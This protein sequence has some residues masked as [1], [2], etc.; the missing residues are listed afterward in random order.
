MPLSRLDL[1]R[2]VEAIRELHRIIAVPP[3]ENW[4]A[5]TWF[6]EQY[7]QTTA[8]E[9]GVPEK[10]SHASLINGAAVE[11]LNRL[12]PPWHHRKPDCPEI[13]ESLLDQRHKVKLIELRNLLLSF[14]LGQRLVDNRCDALLILAFLE[15][16]LEQL[17]A[18]PSAGTGAP[19]AFTG[20]GLTP[21]ES[22]PHLSPT[23]AAALAIIRAEK[24]KGIPAKTIASRLAENGVSIE[25]STLRKHILPKLRPHGIKNERARGGYYDSTCSGGM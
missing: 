21:L 19:P 4:Q 24:G 14:A 22:E 10:P 6:V 8:G 18:E 11:V 25:E 5:P 17:N 2:I 3:A 23:A 16:V 13:T 15:S 7:K 1:P 20:A 12:T 9:A